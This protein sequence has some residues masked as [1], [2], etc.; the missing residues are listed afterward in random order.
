MEKSLRRYIIVV[1]VVAACLLGSH[2]TWEQSIKLGCLPPGGVA[3]QAGWLNDCASDRVG[4]ID[5]AA[6]WFNTEPTI[7][8]AI[9]AAKVLVFGDSKMLGAMSNPSVIDW[10]ESR[11][12]AFYL[13]AFTF[14]EESG[15]A[16][17]LLTKYRPHPAVMIFDTAPYFTGDQSEPAQ[18]IALDPEGERRAA[19]DT[20][21][22][23]G[24]ARKFC[25]YVAWL[26]G[27]TSASYRSYA[28]GHLFQVDPQRFW[29]GARTPGQ[30]PIT[31]PPPADR[32]QYDDYL[33]HARALL[34]DVPIKP[35][36]VVFT[37]VP[38]SDYDG[39]LARFLAAQLGATAIVPQVSGLDTL[40][41]MHL[42]PDSARA[43]TAA[44]LREFEPLMQRCSA[45]PA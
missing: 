20:R 6:V 22:F 32:S 11:H 10:F 44:F 38:N 19:L 34:T 4:D 41:H 8:P 35:A 36:C 18:A 30:Y 31:E 12:I 21:S 29:F 28:D 33:G 26:C 2:E 45:N 27:R 1:L 40:D 16:E 42:T 15:W 24:E 5:H 23:V 9:L 39:S 25:A 43:W 7:K 17:R 37:V 14:A 3:P 13:L